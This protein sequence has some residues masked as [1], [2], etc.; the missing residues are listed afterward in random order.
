MKPEIKIEVG[1]QTTHAPIFNEDKTWVHLCL[2]E[3]IEVSREPLTVVF[4]VSIRNPDGYYGLGSLSSLCEHSRVWG[5]A[6][7]VH[8]SKFRPSFTVQLTPWLEEDESV[9][10]KAGTPLLMYRYYDCDYDDCGHEAC[11]P[12]NQLRFKRRWEKMSADEQKKWASR[13]HRVRCLY[14][15]QAPAPV[16]DSHDENAAH[17]CAERELV[18]RQGS[19]AVAH[20]DVEFEIPFGWHVNC[21]VSELSGLTEFL[22]PAETKIWDENSKPSLELKL[23]QS[24]P[25]ELVVPRGTPLCRTEMI[26]HRC[27]CPRCFLLQNEDAEIQPK[28]DV[29]F[30]PHY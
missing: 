14:L 20:F 17:L 7:S 4:D 18:I 2:E 6:F 3:D 9:K 23:K 29:N 24:G 5:S 13:L 30:N 28:H 1:P 8:V 12:R 26:K 15:R 27:G 11:E 22:E 10:L 25:A 21:T 19:S 16:R